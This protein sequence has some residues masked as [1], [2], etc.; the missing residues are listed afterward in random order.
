MRSNA[1][2]ADRQGDVD[3][4]F[5]QVSAPPVNTSAWLGQFINRNL[6]PV[7]MEPTE[8]S[9]TSAFNIQTPGKYPEE[10]LP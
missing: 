9:E 3:L 1:G 8:C 10:N 4:R 7:K 5:A 6:L 2:M